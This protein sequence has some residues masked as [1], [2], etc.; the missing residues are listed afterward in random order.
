FCVIS[1]ELRR[2]GSNQFVASATIR[3]ISGEDKISFIA[4]VPLGMQLPAGM[5]VQIDSGKQNPIPYELCF[6]NGCYGH[7]A[8]NE[9]FIKALRNGKQL[10]VLALPSRSKNAEPFPMSLAG[11]SK[12]YDSKGLD[13]QA[14]QQRQQDLN[15]ALQAR[16]EEARKKL[17]Q[18]QQ[19]EGGGAA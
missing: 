10:I 3:T 17:I 11:F 19:K 14:A 1:Q 13:A 4:V 9:D 6:A 12:S 8:L 5:R 18:Q 7:M 16:A 2:S 15:K